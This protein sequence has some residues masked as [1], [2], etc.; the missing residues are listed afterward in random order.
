MPTAPGS[1]GAGPL[2]HPDWARHP[3]DNAPA[4]YRRETAARYRAADDAMKK[5][6]QLSDDERLSA[7]LREVRLAPD[8]SPGFHAA[9]WRRLEADDRPAR[10]GSWLEALANLILRTKFA[11]VSFAAVLLAGA[12][13]GSVE[14]RQVARYDAEMSYLASVAPQAGR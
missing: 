2:R 5:N 8:P 14:G 12:V 9:V 1:A 7:L 10:S 3:G 6:E 11:L 13:A 4:R